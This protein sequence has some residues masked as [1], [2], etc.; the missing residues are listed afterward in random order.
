MTNIGVAHLAQFKSREN[1]MAEKLQ[2]ARHFGNSNTLYVNLDND[3][4]QTVANKTWS[5]ERLEFL[6]DKHILSFSADGGAADF[7]AENIHI[8]DWSPGFDFVCD[9]D[10]QKFACFSLGFT[11][12]AMHLWLWRLRCSR[13]QLKGSEGRC[14]EL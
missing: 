5:D 4:L 11:V 9:D 3:M 2:I 13:R 7:R 8:T 12:L 6:R 14:R 1:I 10:K